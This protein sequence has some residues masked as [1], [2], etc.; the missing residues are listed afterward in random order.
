MA[1]KTL[2][3][4]IKIH[5]Q[6]ADFLRRELITLEDELHQLQ[7]LIARLKHEHEQE[8]QMVVSDPSYSKFFG[9]YSV[10]V[11]HKIASIGEEIKRLQEAVEAKRVEISEEYSEQK[12]YE[13]ALDN[14]KARIAEEDKHRLQSR[15]DEVAN[16]QFMRQQENPV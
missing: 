12:K 16:Q 1:V 14:A 4:L 10:H 6:R 2:N 15:F 5:K 9:T 8:M 13:I 7:A 3:T 11:R